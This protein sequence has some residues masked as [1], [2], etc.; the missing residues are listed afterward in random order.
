MAALAFF[1]P[2]KLR[3]DRRGFTIVTVAGLIYGLGSLLHFAAFARID[4]SVAA[5][6]FSLNPL[7]VLG[8]LALAG[9]RLTHR[10][11]VR[12]ILGIA[13]AYPLLGPA[14]QVDLLGSA[15]VF[16]TVLCFA[17]QL[18]LMQ[19]FLRDYDSRMLA[20]YTLVAMWRCWRL[21][22]GWLRAWHGTLSVLRAGWRW[23]C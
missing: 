22:S 16:G 9:E 23:A 18:C 14:G 6:I 2:D 17:I 15:M 10:H 13:G 12:L 4:A 1:A 19:W 7:V 3:I 5:M 21:V 11:T 8:L 20:L